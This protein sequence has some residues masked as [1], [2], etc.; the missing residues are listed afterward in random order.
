MRS[1]LLPLMAVLMLG[2][3]TA[4][5]SKDEALLDVVPADVDNVGMVRLKSVLTQA[6]FEFGADGVKGGVDKRC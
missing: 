4:S 3:V 1:F 5:C 6:G 2:A